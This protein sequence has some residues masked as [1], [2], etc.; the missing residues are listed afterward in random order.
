MFKQ[1]FTL[2]R[3]R[4]VDS[5]EAIL[6][7]NALTLLRQQIRD[8]A[9][10]VEQSRK[11]L[12]TVMAYSEREKA[13]LAAL[14]EK[15]ADL[16]IRAQDA[17]AKD[18]EDLA[19][20]AAITIAH[21]EDERDATSQTIANYT[22]EIARLRDHLSKSQGVLTQLKRGQRIAEANDKAHR[23]HGQ[24]TTLQSSNLEEAA[25]TLKRLQ[26]R[27]AHSDA[28]MA[29]MEQL[30]APENADAMSDRLANAGYG[31][32]KQSSADDVLARLKSKK[33]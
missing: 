27:Q 12:A 25:A 33:S 4:S 10:C 21:L 6:D 15:I 30:S 2:V 24:I 1:I 32:P 20:D 11:A 29:A 9:R 28:T 7:A 5:A 16:E 23:A 31:A 17:L 14:N 8:A 26:D 22:A 18:D 19:R 13:A 3:G